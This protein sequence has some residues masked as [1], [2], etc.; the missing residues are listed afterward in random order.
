MDQASNFHQ[1]RLGINSILLG[2]AGF[3]GS[4]QINGVPFSCRTSKEADVR[5]G[6][7]GKCVL[8]GRAAAT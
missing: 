3:S 7:S 4:P 8:D 5:G 2:F 6:S 1:T